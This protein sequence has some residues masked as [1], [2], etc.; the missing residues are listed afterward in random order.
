MA[1]GQLM[2]EADQ[3]AANRYPNNPAFGQPATQT[4]V[5]ATQIV[6]PQSTAQPSPGPSIGSN[7]GAE[8]KLKREDLGMFNPDAE[9]ISKSGV[10]TEGRNLIFT[11]VFSF[12]QRVLSLLEIE[13][14][15]KPSVDSQLVQ[16][17]GTCLSGSA[18]L[19]WIN[20][21][22]LAGRAKLRSQGIEALLGA[23]VDR[24]KPTDTEAMAQLYKSKFRLY[25][26]L[27]N[28]GAV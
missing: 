27:D 16:L 4:T 26:I 15:R 25:K 17:F 6:V 23:L 1:Q 12:E 28:K 19:W 5:Q 20:E 24:F 8:F 7:P 10:L 22:D 18:M 2:T 21:I 11:D 14:D 3:R 13:P 9:D